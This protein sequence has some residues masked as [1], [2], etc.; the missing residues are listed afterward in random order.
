V[1]VTWA[2]ALSLR[3][4]YP[5]RP[6]APEAVHVPLRDPF[7]ASGHDRVSSQAYAAAPG[8]PSPALFLAGVVR[9]V[10][11]LLPCAL[12]DPGGAETGKF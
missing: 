5:I 6:Y 11:R 7:T 4:R 8:V 9:C 10:A 3:V 12:T 1:E 2:A